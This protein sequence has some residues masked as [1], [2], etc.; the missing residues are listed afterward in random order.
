VREIEEGGREG[1]GEGGRTYRKLRYQT[2][3]FISAPAS[4]ISPSSKACGREGGTE[5]GSEGGKGQSG[6]LHRFLS[7]LSIPPSLPPP[8]PPFLTSRNTARSGLVYSSSSS[9]VA[10]TYMSDE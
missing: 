9:R 6:R 2:M 5:G 1:G 8:L 7:Y 4:H 3:G 10:S